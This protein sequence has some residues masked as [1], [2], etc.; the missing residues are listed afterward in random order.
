MLKKVPHRGCHPSNTFAG[1]QQAAVRLL[2]SSSVHTLSTPIN[3][4]RVSIKA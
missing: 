4:D 1:Q 3:D 2:I